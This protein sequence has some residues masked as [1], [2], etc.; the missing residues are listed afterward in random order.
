MSFQ[1][2]RNMDMFKAFSD[3]YIRDSRRRYSYFLVIFL[4][5]V[6]YQIVM[7]FL[8]G[9]SSDQVALELV[10]LVGTLM[11]G[12]PL[13]SI[14][15]EFLAKRSDIGAEASAAV[16]K[17]N[18][19]FTES[20]ESMVHVNPLVE[21]RALER[22]QHAIEALGKV[23]TETAKRFEL[24]RGQEAN[25]RPMFLSVLREVEKEYGDQQC[26]Y[27]VL[28]ALADKNAWPAWAVRC[29]PSLYHELEKRPDGTV[30]AYVSQY[31]LG[32]VSPSYRYQQL[33]QLCNGEVLKI[34]MPEMTARRVGTLATSLAISLQRNPNKSDRAFIGT[35]I[36]IWS[37]RE[38]ISNNIQDPEASK[39]F[40]L[41]RGKILTEE[42]VMSAQ[43][44]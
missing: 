6:I 13:V 30:V 10:A 32:G 17:L 38:K 40:K 26:A 39:K 33:Q 2:W 5:A 21:D 25:W 15:R 3:F 22:D 18:F 14:G 27:R 37:E 12:L 9:R 23:L 41:E 42:N 16:R 34:A 35:I 4:V 20:A 28:L 31:V 7:D 24:F 43:V 19:E 36:T 11:I 1:M 29:L 8:F 44:A